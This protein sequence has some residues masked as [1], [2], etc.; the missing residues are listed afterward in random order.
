MLRGPSFESELRIFRKHY[1]D[2]YSEK[3]KGDWRFKLALAV[4][5]N[6]QAAGE[7]G[8]IWEQIRPRL[9]WPAEKFIAEIIRRRIVAEEVSK[10]IAAWP[11][12][13]RKLQ[14]DLKRHS[15]N[16][17]YEQRAEKNVLAHNVA[18]ARSTYSREST[19]AARQ[20]FMEELSQ[21]FEQKCQR[22]LDWA[23]AALTG[24][25]FGETV[26]AE[27]VRNNRKSSRK[28]RRKD[29]CTQPTK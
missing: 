2:P 27:A 16:K 21:M 7:P 1:F 3:L 6:W 5:K 15:K 18:Y 12:L 14:A 29:R 25:A 28:T 8:Q 22:P 20:R 17:D 13:E 24:I 4:L 26:T 11:G 19:T 10:T 9:K 23:V